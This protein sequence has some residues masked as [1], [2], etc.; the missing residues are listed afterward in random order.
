M[1]YLYFLIILLISLNLKAQEE[2]KEYLKIRKDTYLKKDYR[3]DVGELY[4]TN[5]DYA[6]EILETYIGARENS[7]KIKIDDE[8]FWVSQTWCTLL[9]KEESNKLMTDW[10]QK[11]ENEEKL[12]IEENKRNAELIIQKQNE[13]KELLIKI[14]EEKANKLSELRK[15]YGKKAEDIYNGYFWI[16]MSKAA[17]ID[18]IGNPEKIN[19]TVGS[20]GVH[21]QY[22]YGNGLYIYIENGIVTS[23]QKSE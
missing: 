23:Y 15:K 5:D 10:I 7:Y 8:E 12:K 21:E 20:W 1:K 22:V 18:S 19:K 2:E 16:G 11:K 3:S 14:A 6:F 9:T 4:V 13:E 17:L